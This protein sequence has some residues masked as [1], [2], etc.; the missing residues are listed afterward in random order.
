MQFARAMPGFFYGVDPSS[1][2]V[3]RSVHDGLVEKAYGPSWGACGRI[4]GP[5]HL[6]DS[7]PCL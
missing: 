7:S 3:R 2:Q 4:I 5:V 6:Q 1:R